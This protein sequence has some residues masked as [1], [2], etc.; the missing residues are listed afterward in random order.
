MWKC[1][2][3]TRSGDH[4]SPWSQDLVLDEMVGRITAP[5][6]FVNK[7]QLIR[8]GRA[9]SCVLRPP[10]A[11]ELQAQGMRPTAQTPSNTPKSN[12]EKQEPDGSPS[13]RNKESPQHWCD[14]NKT[15]F[16]TKH[17]L[18]WCRWI[19]K[20]KKKS[21]GIR[22]EPEGIQ[23]R[24]NFLNNLF[25]GPRFSSDLFSDV[26]STHFY[27]NLLFTLLWGSLSNEQILS[28]LDVTNFLK[29]W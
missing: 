14:D 28:F 20:K 23:I 12:L 22:M 24:T 17:T 11:K 13:E 2:V 27:S 21:T 16:Y 5:L 8:E 25:W 1:K 18:G 26:F 4:L 7:P 29:I 3:S 9:A 6:G 10:S 15:A 19:Q